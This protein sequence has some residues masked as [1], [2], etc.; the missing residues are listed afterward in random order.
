[1]PLRFRAPVGGQGWTSLLAADALAAVLTQRKPRATLIE[2]F[3]VSEN[4]VLIRQIMLGCGLGT[5]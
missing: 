2:F 3:T 1:M 4:H 5:A